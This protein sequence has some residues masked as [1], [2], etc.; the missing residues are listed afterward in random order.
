MKILHSADWHL[1]SPLQGRT[2]Q[3]R[4]ALPADAELGIRLGAFGNLV[5]D[6]SVQ[7]G[8]FDLRTQSRLGEGNGNFAQHIHAVSLKNGVA[9]DADLHI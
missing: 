6:V 5:L 8:D 9:A 7:G 3:L 1:D 4:D 2:T